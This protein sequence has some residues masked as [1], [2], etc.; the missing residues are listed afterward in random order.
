MIECVSFV[1]KNKKCDFGEQMGLCNKVK[2]LIKYELSSYWI[3]GSLLLLWKIELCNTS[4]SCSKNSQNW[5]AEVDILKKKRFIG[6]M[7]HRLVESEKQT[8]LSL[9]LENRLIQGSDIK[10]LNNIL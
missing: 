2:T 9:N 7:W 3:L 8:K 6:K 4:C 10:I 1:K 5:E